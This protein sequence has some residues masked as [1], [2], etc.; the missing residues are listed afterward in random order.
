MLD[1]VTVNLA[2]SDT[3]DPIEILNIQAD[4]IGEYMAILGGKQLIKDIEELHSLHIYLIDLEGNFEL[5]QEFSI[6]ENYRFMTTMFE[7]K[8]NHSDCTLI[9]CDKGSFLEVNYLT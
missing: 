2:E 7:F 5:K 1:A 4:E 8:K 3:D 9:F 6:P